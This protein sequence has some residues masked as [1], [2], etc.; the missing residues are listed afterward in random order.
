MFF[1]ASGR[2]FGSESRMSLAAA[3]SSSSEGG[4]GEGIRVVRE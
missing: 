1:R 3:T 4:G 2:D